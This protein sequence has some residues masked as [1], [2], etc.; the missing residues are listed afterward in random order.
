M[1]F[2]VLFWQER[3]LFKTVE[4][5]QI[6]QC[7]WSGR[8]FKVGLFYEISLFFLI[9]LFWFVSL[10]TLDG[11][12][13]GQLPR[14]STEDRVVLVFEPS[15]LCSLSVCLVVSK[16]SHFSFFH[17]SLF[18]QYSTEECSTVQLFIYKIIAVM[19]DI[20]SSWECIAAGTV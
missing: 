4:I 19:I 15:V 16:F 20:F 1:L 8:L 14:V 2:R 13:I 10:L 7:M 12:L 5:S 3:D 9:L 6:S 18:I 17:S 11:S